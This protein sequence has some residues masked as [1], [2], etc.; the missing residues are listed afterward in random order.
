MGSG[1]EECDG[2]EA[3]QVVDVCGVPHGEV[4]PWLCIGSTMVACRGPGRDGGGGAIV[5]GGSCGA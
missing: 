4:G 3:K 1:E 5:D 2:A